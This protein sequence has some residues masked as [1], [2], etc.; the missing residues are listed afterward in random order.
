MHPLPQA[1]SVPT[2]D[3]NSNT[4]VARSPGEVFTPHKA[5]PTGVFVPDV[6]LA[7]SKLSFGAK[8]VWARLARYA[9]TDGAC[10]P[11]LGTLAAD[12]GCSERQIQR[13]VAELIRAG[14]IAARQRGFNRS[15]LYRFL[16][17]PDLECAARKPPHRTTQTSSC[18]S[19]TEV[20]SSRATPVSPLRADLKSYTEEQAE[21]AREV[22]RAIAP[23][24]APLLEQQHPNQA[25]HW[26]PRRW[27]NS[28]AFRRTWQ[29][30]AQWT[31][32]RPGKSS[33]S[34]GQ[35]ICRPL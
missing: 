28:G 30:A 16:W 25:R 12:L 35:K 29:S 8:L 32:A 27:N 17:H 9:G 7:N 11:A 6:L 34:S 10:F 3:S 4:A 23:P 18:P 2:T 33:R 15:N 24:P 21:R 1:T 26:N 13:Y 31:Q 22:E 14:F 19:A 20:S 5:F